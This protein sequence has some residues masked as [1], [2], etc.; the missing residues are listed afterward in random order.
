MKTVNFSKM[1]HVV[2]KLLILAWLFGFPWA[3]SVLMGMTL[4]MA[5]IGVLK[6]RDRISV[7]D[8]LAAGTVTL[9]AALLANHSALASMLTG[10]VL[11]AIVSSY[12]LAPGSSDL[13]HPIGRT[14]GILIGVLGSYFVSYNWAEL[15]TG[16]LVGVFFTGLLAVPQLPPATGKIEA[17]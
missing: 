12:I 9:T 2:I 14:L 8:L 13:K 15:F 5:I 10:I 3:A 1:F 16:L 4:S 7:A 6:R 11:G 17:P